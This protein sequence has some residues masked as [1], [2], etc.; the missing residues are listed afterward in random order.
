ML[1]HERVGWEHK[2]IGYLD[3]AER[4]GLEWSLIGAFEEKGVCFFEGIEGFF[5]GTFAA[6]NTVRIA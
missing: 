1:S 5:L 2:I 6:V 4:V 3:V